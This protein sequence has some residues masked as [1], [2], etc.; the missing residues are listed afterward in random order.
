MGGNAGAG[1]RVPEF[2]ADWTDSD[3]LES[4]CRD[5]DTPSKIA[6]LFIA[7]RVQGS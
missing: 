4:I 1:A 3:Y 7:N 5:A 6:P 2:A